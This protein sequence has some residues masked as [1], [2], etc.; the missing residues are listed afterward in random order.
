MDRSVEEDDDLVPIDIRRLVISTFAIWQIMMT[1]L[2]LMPG[3][4]L[5]QQSFL[6]PL[7]HYMWLT[8]GDQNW[9]MFA[10]NPAQQ[11]IY[12]SAIITYRDGTQKS[13][14][15]PRMHDLGYIQRYQEERFR[16]MIEF[17]HMSAH[18]CM[19]PPL[20]RFAGLSNNSH[21]A[22]NPVTHVALVLHTLNIPNIGVPLPPYTTDTFYQADY[23]PGGLT[24]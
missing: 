12:L 2:W 1:V 22:T 14:N 7:R 15:F 13:W 6:T 21:P 11:D 19:W 8:G 16:K 18:S 3:G 9:A 17:G 4:S 20:A 24:R 5:V 10:P 23:G